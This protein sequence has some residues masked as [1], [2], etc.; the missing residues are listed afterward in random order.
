MTSTEKALVAALR[1][2][3]KLDDP[4]GDASKFGFNGLRQAQQIA[5]DALSK[6]GAAQ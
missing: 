4:A 6:A 2:I 5:R 1:K 3:E